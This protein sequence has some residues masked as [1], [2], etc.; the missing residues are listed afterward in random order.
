VQ[1]VLMPL[2]PLYDGGPSG[3]DKCN[4]QNCTDHH[5]FNPQ[6]KCIE[7]CAAT[8]VNGFW[9]S[10]PSV[11]ILGTLRHFCFAA[12]RR[13]PDRVETTQLPVRVMRLPHQLQIRATSCATQERCN[14]PV[15][16]PVTQQGN[17]HETYNRSTRVSTGSLLHVCVRTSRR[18]WRIGREFRRRFVGGNFGRYVC[19][20]SR[21]F[22]RGFLNLWQEHPGHKHHH[23]Q[24]HRF[25]G[26]SGQFE[27]LYWH[28]RF[29]RVLPQT[30]IRLIGITADKQKKRRGFAQ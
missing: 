21:R 9:I 26:Q 15:V 10:A 30:T 22:Q 14:H 7:D 8:V 3:N 28:R 6:R 1:N 13:S 4:K 23:R 17:K 20:Y 19:W 27:Q 25:D 16:A 24:H 29:D 2:E 5:V 12:G 18:K 11:I